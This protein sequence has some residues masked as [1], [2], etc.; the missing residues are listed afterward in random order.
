MRKEH[1]QR[2]L[3]LSK[4][5]LDDGDYNDWV[6]TTSFYSAVHFVEHA[7]FPLIENGVEYSN[8]NEYWQAVSYPIHVSKHSCKKNLVSKYISSIKAE[9]R[10]LL[11]DCSTARYNN[12]VVT[13][14][15]A[16]QAKVKADKIKIACLAMKP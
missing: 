16:N 8:F 15:N 13:D 1:G 14:Y 6:V 2:N 5:L 4:I 9:Y 7:L 12:Y 11:D 10:E 3:N